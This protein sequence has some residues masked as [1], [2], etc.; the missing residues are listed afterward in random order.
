MG[1]VWIQDEYMT[2]PQFM[3]LTGCIHVQAPF[4][5][6]ER[7]KTPRRMLRQE[8]TLLKSEEHLRYRPPVKQGHLPVAVP[9]RV[10]FT[11]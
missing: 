7:Y 11:T 5:D 4:D 3:L 1:D 8:A 9:G 2:F 10:L 6:M